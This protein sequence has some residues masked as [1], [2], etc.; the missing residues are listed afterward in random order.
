MSIYIGGERYVQNGH[1]GTL[2]PYDVYLDGIRRSHERME[3]RANAIFTRGVVGF[4]GVPVNATIGLGGL[5]LFL[6][7]HAANDAQ[8][9]TTGTLLMAESAVGGTLS[10]AALVDAFTDKL[11]RL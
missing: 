1:H 3:Q 6:L 8:T 2:M 5:G 10:V 7:G 4:I 11:H 9:I